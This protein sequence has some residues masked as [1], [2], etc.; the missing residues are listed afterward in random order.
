M[1]LAQEPEMKLPAE[2]KGKY[3]QLAG[4]KGYFLRGTALL[5]SLKASE[6]VGQL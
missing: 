5:T 2:N 1:L 3:V 6:S 4:L